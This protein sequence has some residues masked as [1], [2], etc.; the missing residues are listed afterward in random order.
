MGKEYICVAKCFELDLDNEP[1]C[2]C[3]DLNEWYE[4]HPDCCYVGN[5]PIWE[6]VK[7]DLHE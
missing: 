1:H 2:K 6:E 7:E 5:Q 4:D 3:K